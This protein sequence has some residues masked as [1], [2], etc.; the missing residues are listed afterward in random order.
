MNA[1]EPD[2]QARG[3]AVALVRWALGLMFLVGGVAKLFML[4]GFVSGYLLPAFEKTFL[5]AWLVG[6]Y[7]YALPFVETILG[8]LLLV[9]LCRR[10]ALLT[11]GLT[12]ISLAF[13]QMLIQGHGIVAN[14]MLYVLMTAAVLYGQEYDTLVLP[15]CRCKSAGPKTE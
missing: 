1:D 12:L 5:P 3:L 9:G 2:C 8:V 6:L 7:G 4:K 13:G 10:A 14:I 15:G 11:A